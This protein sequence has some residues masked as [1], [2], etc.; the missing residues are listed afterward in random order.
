M[1]KQKIRSDFNCL[2]N[3]K[4]EKIY[5]GT[6]SFNKGM[7]ISSAVERMVLPSGSKHGKNETNNVDTFIIIIHDTAMC[8][9]FSHL[10]PFMCL[11]M[12]LCLYLKYTASVCLYMFKYKAILLQICEQPLDTT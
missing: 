3:G 12:S 2:E 7:E 10:D 4:T 1:S 9:H 11:N 6:C 5:A 8:L